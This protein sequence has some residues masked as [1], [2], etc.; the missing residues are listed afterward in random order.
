MKE[1]R[2]VGKFGMWGE[3]ETH[4]D[5]MVRDLA[6]C[7]HVYGDRDTFHIEVREVGE[8]H[9]FEED[10]GTEDP[11]GQREEEAAQAAEAR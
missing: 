3:V 5:V 1:Y 8:W 11:E 10:T 4:L 7:K 9:G 6:Y 2:L